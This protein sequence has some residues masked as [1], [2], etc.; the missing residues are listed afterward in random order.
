MIPAILVSTLGLAGYGW[1]IQLRTHWFIPTLCFGAI[2]FG[3]ILGST[4]AVTYCLD[5][6]KADAIGTQV[7]LSLMKSKSSLPGYIT[8]YGTDWYRHPRAC[9]L[10]VRCRLG[11]GLRTAQYLL[12]HRWDSFRLPICDDFYVYSWETVSY[13]DGQA[14]FIACYLFAYMRT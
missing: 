10:F 4:I 9:V 8:L 11:Q 3:C 14:K 6:H 2:Y 13:K 5:C 7:V 12:D 1:S